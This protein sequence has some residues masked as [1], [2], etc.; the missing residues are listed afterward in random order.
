MLTTILRKLHNYTSTHFPLKTQTTLMGV[1]LLI[2]AFAFIFSL[3]SSINFYDVHWS[4]A[5]RPLHVMIYACTFLYVLTIAPIVA[6]AA[7]DALIE[8]IVERRCRQ[9]NEPKH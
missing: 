9:N 2:L 1:S 8:T 7:A 3:L 6:A 5:A 4:G